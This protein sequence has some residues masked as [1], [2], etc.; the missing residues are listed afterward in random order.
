MQKKFCSEFKIY[1]AAALAA[2]MERGDKG[3]PT[4]KGHVICPFCNVYY[5][6]VEYLSKHMKKSHEECF[7]CI[8]NGT[9]QGEYHRDYDALEEHFRK[10]HFI[11]D[12]KECLEQKF[13]VYQSKKELTQHIRT[14]H[15]DFSPSKSQD[16]KLLARAMPAAHPRI[17]NNPL[18]D[19]PSSSSSIP[20]SRAF[21]MIPSSFCS[22]GAQLSSMALLSSPMAQPESFSDTNADIRLRDMQRPASTGTPEH[23]PK[24]GLGSGKP[25]V[26]SQE[27]ISQAHDSL[28]AYQHSLLDSILDSDTSL[29]KA[30]YE[31]F[32]KFH[33]QISGAISFT[34][35]ISDMLV[36]KYSGSQL[37]NKLDDVTFFVKNLASVA[38]SV[39]RGARLDLGSLLFDS[40]NAEMSELLAGLPPDEIPGGFSSVKSNA[41]KPKNLQSD[42]VEM[43]P[44]LPQS[45]SNQPVTSAAN[46]RNRSFSSAVK[47]TGARSPAVVTVTKPTL[48]NDA[49]PSLGPSHPRPSQPSQFHPPRKPETPHPQSRKPAQKRPEFPPLPQNERISTSSG[50]SVSKSVWPHTNVRT[51]GSSKKATG[52]KR[53]IALF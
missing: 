2:H 34:K 42:S 36:S 44:S 11:C 30:F 41:D 53:I 27:A 7:L 49:F 6:D 15:S 29:I 5:Y 24:P 16:K 35:H 45:S 31:N 26:L 40:W 18:V 46:C 3:D 13:V 17:R 9:N 1:S 22:N 23:L 32:A 39:H 21:K 19:L 14:M 25:G 37:R 8:Q 28:T 38:S 20:A 48:V 51:Y 4:I 12:R 33:F 43:F 50:S 52:S 47:R 10:A